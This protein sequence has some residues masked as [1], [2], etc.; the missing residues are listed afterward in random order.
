MAAAKSSLR[1]AG[2][3]IDRDEMLLPGMLRLKHS[4]PQPSI[5]GFPVSHSATGR[6]AMPIDLAVEPDVAV[7]SVDRRTANPLRQ[8]ECGNASTAGLN[9]WQ[10]SL[11]DAR[12]RR[13]F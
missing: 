6:Q 5:R 1:P 10:T 4:Y 12:L 11:T 3:I 8:S 13:V 2:K 9:Q 7:L